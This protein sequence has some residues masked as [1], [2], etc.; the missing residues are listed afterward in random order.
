MSNIAAFYARVSSDSQ[1]KQE[2]IAS[3]IAEIKE[4]IKR[5]GNMLDES[6]QFIDDGWSGELLDRPALDA[7]RDAMAR[8]AFEILYVYDL[9]RLSRMYINQLLLIEEIKII[10]IKLVSLH[11]INAETDEQEFGQRVMSE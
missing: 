2:T 1:E 8:K 9:G 7:M 3:Q 5:D 11:D 4:R 10:G 6:N